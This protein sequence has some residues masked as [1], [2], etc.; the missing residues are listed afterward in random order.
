MHGNDV[1]NGGSSFRLIVNNAIMTFKN[2]FDLNTQH[3]LNF[4]QSK[5]S[6]NVIFLR[7]MR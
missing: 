5:R 2:F 4:M 7:R 3:V 6:S 1:S